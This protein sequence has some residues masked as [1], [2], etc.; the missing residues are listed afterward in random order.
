MG[1]A[2]GRTIWITTIPTTARTFVPITVTIPAGIDPSVATIEFDYNMIGVVPIL[3]GGAVP[4][5]GDTGE[6]RIWTKDGTEARDGSYVTD[7]PSDSGDFIV[8]NQPIKASD[9]GLSTRTRPLRFT[10]R[11]WSSRRTSTITPT[12]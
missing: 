9:L 4:I 5:W 6:V 2:L 8:T 3:A 11:A 12:F 7:D 10:W 1:I